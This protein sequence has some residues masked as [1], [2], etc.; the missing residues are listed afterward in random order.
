MHALE[1]KITALELRKQGLT[2]SEIIS[3][4]PRGISKSTLSYWC[5]E[6]RLAESQKLRINQISLE[7]LKLALGATNPIKDYCIIYKGAKTYASELTIYSRKMCQ[8]LFRFGIIPK[9]SLVL[10]FPTWLI[11]HPFVHHFIRGYIDG[12]GCFSKRIQKGRSIA[13]YSFSI[14]GTPEF[15]TCLYKIV[16]KKCFNIERDKK[17]TM[18]KNIGGIGY[19]GNNVVK[20]IA[21]FLYE[22]ATEYLDRKYNKIEHFL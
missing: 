8:D 5:K 13:Q 2:F 22:N 3:H 18:T 16:D 15:L 7:K 6:V 1:F 9:K 17:I 19:S 21:K 4:L 20:E 12:D 11:D 10:K 14:R